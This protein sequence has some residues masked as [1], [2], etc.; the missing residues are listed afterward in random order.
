M[1]GNTIDKKQ[2]IVDP[3]GNTIID[4]TTSIF[5]PSVRASDT[6]NVKKLSDK[7]VMRPDKAA[8]DEYGKTEDTEFVLKYTG[9]SNPFSLDSNDILVFPD[10]TI[11][12]AQMADMAP[13][14]K[15]SKAA[16]IKNYYKFTNK[17][18]KSDK[19]S[20]DNI[21]NLSIPDGTPTAPSDDYM[22]PYI[23]EDGEASITIRNGRMYFGED[24]TTSVTN[25]DKKIQS[26]IDST[27]S[28]LSDKCAINGLSL[29]DFV[30]ASVKNQ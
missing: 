4:L 20:Y 28:T 16:Q 15:E 5:S 3:N 2:Q 21:E 8:F 17:D 11:A 19:T 23:S 26:L 24:N 29:A 7:Y 13:E 30:R 12:K 18:Y 14:V 22:V 27:V 10:E 1:F 9:I 25:M 6:Y